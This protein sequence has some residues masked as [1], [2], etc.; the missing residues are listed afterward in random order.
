M[1][2]ELLLELKQMLVIFL[3]LAASSLVA[4]VI[5]GLFSYRRLR[6]LRLPADADFAATLRAVPLLLV[7]ITISSV[8]ASAT[9]SSCWPVRSRKRS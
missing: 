5:I 4:A 2:P 9:W 8:T 7:I 6:A 1:K 3:G